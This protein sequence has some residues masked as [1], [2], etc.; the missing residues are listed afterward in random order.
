M[1]LI[2]WAALIFLAALIYSGITKK[3]PTTTESRSATSDESL[4]MARIMS[5]ELVKQRLKSPSSA[6]F[7]ASPF[8]E[9]LGNKTYSVTGYV[10]SQNSFGAM[11][12]TR[13]NAV[14]RFNYVTGEKE[15][16]SLVSF[17]EL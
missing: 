14:V 17:K 10:D 9:L 15:S 12:R 3:E 2:S 7:S 4:A 8:I 6:K 5:E 13:Y 1:K 11:I 16:W